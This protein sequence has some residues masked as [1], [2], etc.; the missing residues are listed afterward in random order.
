MADRC[1]I[2]FKQKAVI[3]FL[4]FEGN[5]AKEISDRL[6]NVYGDS[7]LSYA[8]VKRWVTH[9]KSGDS[10][11]TDKPRSG[12]PS[13]AVIEENRVLVDELIR[14]D[15]RITVREIVEK[16]GTGHNAAQNIIRELGYSKVCAR[17][18]PRQLTDE[19]KRS[20]REICAELLERY[21]ME[22]DQF[23][24]SI[25]TGDESWAHHYEPETKRQSMQ[26]HHLGS[27][28]PK[29]FKCSP[30]AGKVMMTVFWD[31]RG[32][33]FI[34]FLPKGKTVNS[35]RYCDT[36]QKLARAIRVKRPSMQKVILH[37][38]NA[39]PH[40]AHATAAAIAAKGWTVLPHPAYSPDLAPSD[41]HIFGPLKDYLRGQKFED[42]DG[43]QTAAKAWFRQCSADFFSNGFVNW[44][45]RWEK[46]VARNG[47]YIEK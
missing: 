5:A 38:D 47:D 36:L 46:C 31:H 3:E 17:W 20:R 30:S 22:G 8:S 34:D 23:M 26:W 13:T 1:D 29:K 4:A 15:R 42:D 9:F 25:V 33:I 2:G 7:A 6:K 40:T 44:R 19:L 39:R 41:F 32:V 37:H 45:T 43:V 10:S 21:R 18:I 35:D 27:P 14:G 28:S 16:I 11:I 24:N 12:R